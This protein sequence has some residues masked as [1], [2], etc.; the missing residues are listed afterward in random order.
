MPVLLVERTRADKF[1]PR[2]P[3]SCS[4]F[5]IALLLYDPARKGMSK[6][7]LM[8]KANQLGIK[9]V[10]EKK[11]GYYDGWTGNMT[12]MK[13]VDYHWVILVVYS[14]IHIYTY[15]YTYKFYREKELTIKV[16]DLWKLTERTGPE[17]AEA[18]HHWVHT[19]IHTYM[20]IH[21]CTYIHAHTYIRHFLISFANIM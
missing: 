14:Y 6:E 16:K 7:D 21:T 11:N 17:V 18:V 9:D 20:H 10:Y 3:S 4:A 2:M 8:Q 5:L 1:V 15:I 12:K 19:Y 13:Y